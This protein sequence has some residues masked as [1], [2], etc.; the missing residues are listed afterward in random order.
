MDVDRLTIADWED[1]D[2][3]RRVLDRIATARSRNERLSEGDRVELS[4]SGREY[5]VASDGA[6]VKPKLQV[7]G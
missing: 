6:W 1:G 3:K 7:P 5:V 2:A 4:V